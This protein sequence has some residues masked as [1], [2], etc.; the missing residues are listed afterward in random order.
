MNSEFNGLTSSQQSAVRAAI[1]SV[2]QDDD[3]V[4]LRLEDES[5]VYAY[6]GADGK[7]HWGVNAPPNDR[8]IARGVV[9]SGDS[10]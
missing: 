10:L 6:P 3:R 5:E 7:V 2:R 8:N 1:A 4:S 9:I